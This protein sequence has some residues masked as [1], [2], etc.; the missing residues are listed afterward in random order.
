MK[1][2]PEQKSVLLISVSSGSEQRVSDVILTPT[3]QKVE[4]KLPMSR[5]L[6]RNLQQKQTQ[7]EEAAER[8]ETDRNAGTSVLDNL[9]PA[10]TIEQEADRNSCENKR[11]TVIT[12]SMKDRRSQKHGNIW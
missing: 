12:A 2:L 5:R 7:A 10:A 6:G 4:E 9:E 8:K 11:C 1:Y 3:N